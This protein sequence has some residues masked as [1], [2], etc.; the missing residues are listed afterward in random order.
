M[1]HITSS[2]QQHLKMLS[3]SCMAKRQE[4]RVLIEAL[5]TSVGVRPKFKYGLCRLVALDYRKVA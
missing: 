3:K 4:T 2:G 5:S 1:R